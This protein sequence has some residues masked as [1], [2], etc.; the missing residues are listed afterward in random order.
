MK[1]QTTFLLLF[2]VFGVAAAVWWQRG[3]EEADLGAI[4]VPLFEGV[5]PERIKALRIDHLERGL[6]LRLERDARGAWYITDP[7]LYPADLSVVGVLLEV[8]GQSRALQ[9]PEVERDAGELGLEPPRA[10]FI[11]VEEVGGTTVEHRVELG[12]LDLDGQRLNVHKDG[13]F[14]RILRK[15]DTTLKRSVNDFRSRRVMEIDPAAVVELNRTGEHQPAIEDMPVPLR[16][17]AIRDGSAWRSLVPH[18]ALLDPL[19]VGVILYGAAALQVDTFVDDAPVSLAEYGLDEPEIRIEL[20]TADGSREALRV[21]RSGFGGSWYACREHEPHVFG[22]TQED[23]QRLVLPFEQLL[24][25]SIARFAREDVQVL[26]LECDE[27]AVRIERAGAGWTVSE[28][29]AGESGASTPRPAEAARVEKLLSELEHAEL[30]DFRLHS[31]FPADAPRRG[32]YVELASATIG[33]RIGPP[34][35]ES[36]GLQLFLFERLGDGI[37]ALAQ[38]ALSG[39]ACTPAAELRALELVSLLEVDLTGLT[40]RRG[41]AVLRYAR[42]DRG[43]WSRGGEEAEAAELFP[44]LDPLIFLRAR[45]HL[46]ES[47]EPLAD[48][49]EVVFERRD[50]SVLRFFVGLFTPS[51]PEGEP[52]AVADFEGARS[53][54]EVAD[55]HERLR[56]LFER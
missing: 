40:V 46:G 30:A 48:P 36:D 51:E 52:R 41:E 42:A 43:R 26:R 47:T 29:L 16:L 19:D 55:I 45:E 35:P 54:L 44:V 9:V 22:L 27:R 56:A 38:P 23:V 4:D 39:L 24:D 34:A 5:R 37:V 3:R 20:G 10:I 21:S 7:I 53:L 15:L 31:T 2:L 33:G 1:K 8:I 50:G 13:R 14:L 49:I 12:H 25:R 32:V 6:A 28:S 11:A 17:S 18:E